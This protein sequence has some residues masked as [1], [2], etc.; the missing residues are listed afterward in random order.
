MFDYNN[1]IKNIVLWKKKPLFWVAM[2]FLWPLFLIW[3]LGLWSIR[4]IKTNRK[5]KPWYKTRGVYG[6]IVVV[7]IL[8]SFLHPG[9][10]NHQSAD[11]STQ[12]YSSSSSSEDDD[13][14][15]KDNDNSESSD[16]SEAQKSSIE[17]AEKAS[18]DAEAKASSE[19]AQSY[20]IAASSQSSSI[21]EASSIAESQSRA[22]SVAAQ[23]ATE[24]SQATPT[25]EAADG[26]INNTGRNKWAIQ[27]GFTWQTRKGHST[28]IAPGQSLPAGYHWEV[29]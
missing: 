22:N 20:L 4:D 26:N 10:E 6:L 25:T 9:T 29:Q 23:Q 17:A 7:V 12:S 8:F 2:I 24:Q 18:A 14:V 13:D 28:V 19:A 11:Q 16:S 1:F 27:D 15:S 3:I 21:A 5:I